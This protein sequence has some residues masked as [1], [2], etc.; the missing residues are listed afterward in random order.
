MEIAE[1]APG[2]VIRGTDE[3]VD[4]PFGL[5][6][7][8]WIKLYLPLVLRHG[9]KQSPAHRPREM[10]AGQRRQAATFLAR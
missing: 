10:R 4:I 2:M 5:V 9:L 3:Y 7:L 8:Y 1:G 6:G